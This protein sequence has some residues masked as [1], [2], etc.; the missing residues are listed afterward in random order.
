MYFI[1]LSHGELL[2]QSL[3]FPPGVVFRVRDDV[4]SRRLS[5]ARDMEREVSGG[6]M[7][8]LSNTV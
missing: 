2:R 5:I 1:Y 4:E 6:S 3:E 7:S 8:F